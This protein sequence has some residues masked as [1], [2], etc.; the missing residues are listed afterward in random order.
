MQEITARLLKSPSLWLANDYTERDNGIKKR[1][2]CLR[3]HEARDRNIELWTKLVDNLL[4]DW[5][6]L[7]MF[8]W[9]VIP[10]G[11]P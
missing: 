5:I 7:A 1:P 3:L 4:E 2:C 9:G 8:C 11:K 6:R 10:A